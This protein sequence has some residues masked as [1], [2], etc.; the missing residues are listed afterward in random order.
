M[1]SGYALLVRGSAASGRTVEV[2]RLVDVTQARPIRVVD[3][4]DRRRHVRRTKRLEQRA[5]PPLPAIDEAPGSAGG[6]GPP[7]RRREELRP[8]VRLEDRCVE[9]PAS[10]SAST[11][12]RSTAGT[13][14]G[15]SPATTITRST[16]VAERFEPGRDRD[17]RPL[18]R[19]RIADQPDVRSELRWSAR[20]ARPYDHDLVGDRRTAAMARAPGAVRPSTDSASLSRPKRVERPPASTIAP[21]DPVIDA[22]RPRP[23]R[24]P[25]SPGALGPGTWPSGVRRRIARRSRSSRIA[26]TYLRLVPVASR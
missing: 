14:H 8:L 24:R 2:R 1:P 19:P 11:R 18:E 9:I 17:E 6:G 3:P 5:E 10:S 13:S 12:C 7:H 16:S 20:R 26:M 22:R 21:T 15:M 4:P 25:P 23:G